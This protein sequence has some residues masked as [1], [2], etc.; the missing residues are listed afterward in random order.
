MVTTGDDDDYKD[1]VDEDEDDDYSPDKGNES[2]GN[3]KVQR[4]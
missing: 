3:Q 1:D 2:D 4:S